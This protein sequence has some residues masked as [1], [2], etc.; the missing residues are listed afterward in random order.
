MVQDRCTYPEQ[1]WPCLNGTRLIN[2]EVYQPYKL[3]TIALRCCLLRCSEY[4]VITNYCCSTRDCMKQCYNL[5]ITDTNK[6]FY[7]FG[8]K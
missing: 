6:N 2:G 7:F 5:E 1:Q 8:K 3:E 4:D